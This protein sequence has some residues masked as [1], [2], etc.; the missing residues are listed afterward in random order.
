MN[1]EIEIEIPEFDRSSMI[2][3]FQ[4]KDTSM[5]DEFIISTL[6]EL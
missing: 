5:C 6:V 3:P 1:K 4:M 2:M